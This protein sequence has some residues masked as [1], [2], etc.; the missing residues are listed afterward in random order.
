[1]LG[2]CARLFKD[3]N[4]LFLRYGLVGFPGLVFATL[5]KAVFPSWASRL[6]DGNIEVSREESRYVRTAAFF[7]LATTESYCINMGTR[8]SSSFRTNAIG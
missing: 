6:I 3:E 8:G 2:I 4:R 1:M 7:E 5:T